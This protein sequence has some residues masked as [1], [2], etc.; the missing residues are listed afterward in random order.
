MRTWAVP[1]QVKRVKA[2][3]VWKQQ[4]TAD[5]QQPRYHTARQKTGA[6]DHTKKCLGVIVE[7]T[8]ILG[9]AHILR[10]ILSLH[11]INF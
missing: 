8:S 10:K 1:E 5:M 3:T 9:T 4:I 11:V 2:V 7:M 6:T